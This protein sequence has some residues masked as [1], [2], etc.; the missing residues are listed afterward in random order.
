MFIKKVLKQWFPLAVVIV[1]LGGLA[2]AIGQQ[3]YRISA[4]DPQIQMAEDGAAA[5][6]AGAAPENLVPS[7]KVDVAHS[8]SPFIVVLD[9]TGKVISANASLNGQVPP[10]PAGVLDYVR[11][12]GED[13][14]TMQP[15][16]GV[17]FAAVIT[18][19]TGLTN[20]FILAGRSLREVE[21]RSDNLFKLSALAILVTLAACLAAVIFCQWIFGRRRSPAK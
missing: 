4:N 14:V 21:I 2:Y 19:F 6:S 11:V 8:L 15:Q 13:R 3:V 9:D 5:L 7:G 12:K 17:R 20:G 1:A 18:R 10:I 16:P